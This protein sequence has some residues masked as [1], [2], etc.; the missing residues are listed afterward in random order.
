MM[1]GG[2]AGAVGG[3]DATLLDGDTLVAT[4]CCTGLAVAVFGSNSCLSLLREG[5]LT[6]SSASFGVF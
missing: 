1:R 2:G 6:G 4:T 3:G 5:A